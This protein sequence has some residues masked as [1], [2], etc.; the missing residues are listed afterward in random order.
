MKLDAV[1]KSIV[2]ELHEISHRIRGDFRIKLKRLTT[3]AELKKISAERSGEWRRERYRELQD[4]LAEY[5]ATADKML[6][7][8]L[9]LDGVIIDG[10]TH[11]SDYRRTFKKCAEDFER[12]RS[13]GRVSEARLKIGD[14]TI[15]GLV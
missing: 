9:L 6:E 12:V 8:E 11:E 3:E 14:Q 15:G 13:S 7:A 1:I 4:A 2:G 10:T 5:I